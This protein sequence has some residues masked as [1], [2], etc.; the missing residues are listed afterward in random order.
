MKLLLV[1]AS[2]LFLALGTACGGDS[3]PEPTVS[4]PT[5]TAAAQVPSPTAQAA[6][7]TATTAAP[8]APP[9]SAPALAAQPTATTAPAASAPPPSAAVQEVTVRAGESGQNYYFQVSTTSL[10]T[11]KVKVTMT[12]AGPERPHT[13]VVRS[14]NTKVAEISETQPG[15]TRSVEF[16]LTS[17]GTYQ[18]VCDLRGHADRGQSGAFTVS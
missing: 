13:F 8:A 5:A 10:T 9:T 2:L 15:Q 18:F 17:A 1:P 16:E 12:N 6:L 11:G 4:A 3:D 14:G 7:P